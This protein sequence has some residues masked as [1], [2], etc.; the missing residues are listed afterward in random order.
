MPRTRLLLLMILALA[1]APAAAQVESR[2]GIAL[3]NQI[4]QLRQEVEMLRR[5][6]G[7]APVPMPSAPVSPGDLTAQ[8]LDRIARLEE[9]ARTLRGRADTA[10]NQLRQAREAIQKL[11]GDMDFRFQQLQGGAR[12]ATPAPPRS[13]QATPPAAA[14]TPAQALT[15]G[16]EALGRRDFPAA[17]AA[18]REVLA[19]NDRARRVD[20]NLLLGQALTGRNRHQDAAVA[21][22]DAYRGSQRGPRAPEAL[23]GFASAL[24]SLGARQ[25]AC[26]ALAEVASNFPNLPAPRQR[27]ADAVRTRARC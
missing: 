22:G 25:D 3:Q 9:E 10:E 11:E 15:Q 18:A 23:I 1:A 5:Q 20:A 8:L 2:E 7:V 14:R 27:E 26:N 19:A 4:L 16:Q 6:G 13:G 21:F 17:E 12:P 24:A